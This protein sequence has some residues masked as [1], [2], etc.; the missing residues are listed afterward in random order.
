V[1]W[2]LEGR[3]K[4][5]K[6]YGEVNPCLGVL[7]KLEKVLGVFEGLHLFNFKVPPNWG[8]LGG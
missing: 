1:S 8:V 6:I 7:K 5:G 4:E 2:V 3:G